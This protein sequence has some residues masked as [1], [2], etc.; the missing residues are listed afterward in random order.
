MQAGGELDGLYRR[1]DCGTHR[2]SLRS[3][4][5]D[6][7]GLWLTPDPVVITP[8]RFY[9]PQQLNAYAYVRNSPTRLVDPTGAI[10][11]FSGDI[12][13]D[14]EELCKIAGDNLC[15]R[16]SVDKNG[17]VSFD[18]AGLDLSTN[19]GAAL[20]SDLVQSNNTFDF[21]EGPTVETAGG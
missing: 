18:T 15:S 9:D 2:E 4:I 14:K 21:S 5:S 8:E 7:L 10:L 16:I 12:A 3:L 17:V 20:I 19:E 11:H 6:C 13:A 1:R